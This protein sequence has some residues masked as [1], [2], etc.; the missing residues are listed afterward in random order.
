MKIAHVA[1]WTRRLDAQ[2]AFW[3][4]VFGGQSNER[5]V[6]K[7]RPGFASHFITLEGGP[8]IELMT[9]PDLPDAPAHPEF[10]GWA[11]IAIDVGSRARVDSMAEQARAG[12]TLLSAPR[13][14]GDG[15]YEAVI[16]DPDGNRVELVGA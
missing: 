9:V 12:D 11:H 15:F 4:T 10:V 13:M 16:A 5:Y 7:N 1:L 8:T 6:S 14:T 2:V 3:T